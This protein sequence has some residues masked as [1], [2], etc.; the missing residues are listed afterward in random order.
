[1]PTGQ[2]YRSAA[3]LIIL[4]GVVAAGVAS[5]VPFYTVGYRLHG[6][7][8]AMVLTPFVVYG[9]FAYSLRGPWLLGSGLILLGVTLF[10]VVSERFMH[11]HEYGEPTLYWLPLLVIAIVLPIAYLFGKRAPYLTAVEPSVQEGDA[12]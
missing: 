8:L 12:E 10:V 1:M 4:V 5:V 9:M 6:V 3:Y 2:K 11:R 7:T